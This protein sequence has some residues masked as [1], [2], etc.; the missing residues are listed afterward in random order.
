MSAVLKSN[1]KS[2]A[3]EKR[4]SSTNRRRDG[5][6]GKLQQNCGPPPKHITANR[7]SLEPHPA[8]LFVLIEKISMEFFV[9]LF[10]RI[11]TTASII[12]Q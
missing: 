12:N 4:R 3:N 1:I 2:I 8:A 9:F 7:S 5:K 11:L 6:G 10:K